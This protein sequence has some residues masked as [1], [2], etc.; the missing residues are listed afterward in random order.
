MRFAEEDDIISF[1]WLVL[2]FYKDMVF[3]CGCIYLG[4]DICMYVCVCVYIDRYMSC[5]FY[6]NKLS[7]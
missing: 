5:K 6:I 1:C 3:V 4:I 2:M 7:E